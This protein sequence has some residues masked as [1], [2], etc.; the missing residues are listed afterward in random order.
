[1]MDRLFPFQLL[2]VFALTTGLFISLN[3][4]ALTIKG[5]VQE[6]G[7]RIPLKEVNVFIIPL[8]E[9]GTDRPPA[10]KATTD[11]KGRFE[12]TDVPAGAFKM[13]VNLPDYKKYEQMDEQ[14][15]EQTNSTRSIFVER[16]KYDAFE[17]VVTSK[18][19]KK[20]L[21]Q[22]T[23]SQAEFLSLP[24]SQGDPVKAVQNLPGVNRAGGFSSQVIIQGSAPKDTKYNIDGHEIPLV[25]HF[26]G[27]SSVVMPE[28]LEAVNY[29]SAGYESDHSRAIGGIISLQTKDP[30]PGERDS[31]SFFFIDTL[32]A[33]GLYEKRIDE[34]STYLISARHSYIGLVL[35]KIAE[36]R[37]DFNLTVVPEFSDFTA[38]YNKELSATE[39]FKLVTIAS[40]DSLGF[41]LKE[42]FKADPAFRGTFSNETIFYRLIPQWDKKLSNDSQLHFSIAIGRDQIRVDAGEQYFKLGS[43]VLTTRGYWDKQWFENEEGNLKTQL[44]FDNNYNQGKVAVKL[45]VSRDEGGVRDPFSSGTVKETEVTGRN[46]N[47]GLYAKNEWVT[48]RGTILPSLRLDSFSDT[49]ERLLSPRLGLKYKASDSLDLKMAGGLYYQPPEGVESDE[50]FGN[51]DVKSPRSTHFTV[52]FENDF[53]KGLKSGYVLSASYFD[54]WM[55]KLVIPSTLLVDR[56]GSITTEN[57]NNEGGGRAYGLELQLKFTDIFE[58]FPLTGWVSYTYS[59]SQRWNPL[60]PAYDSENDQTHNLNI[61]AAH[62]FENNWKVSGRY[63]YVTGNPNTPIVGGVFDADNDVY[64]PIRGAFFSERFKDFQQLDLRFDKKY[65]L[66]QEIWTF[67]LDIQNVLNQQNPERYE[68]AYDYSKRAEVSGL[69]FLP[70]IGVKGEF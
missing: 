27:F 35:G 55:E 15:A 11:E 14:S 64:T 60:L 22:K 37:S 43:N 38:I 45:P 61:I 20:D 56:G 31:K 5:T 65:V 63:R 25:F 67:Y 1:M 21:T 52:G 46:R 16:E 68:Y 8:A 54:K 58:K 28:G 51:P 4:E 18:R 10:I 39:N 12:A 57:Y 29:L 26:G 44:G 9:D 30:N 13:I 53:R 50:T 48:G 23:L 40:R 32:K 17:I 7:T 70:A 34:T 19:K 47:I 36:R 41:L 49:K 62:D 24:G 59:R 2:A 6:K 66:D 33:G 42:P 3:L 69:P